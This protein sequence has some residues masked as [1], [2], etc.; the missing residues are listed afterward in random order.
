MVSVFFVI[1]GYALSLKPLKMMR[2]RD[3]DGFATTMTSFIFRRG[4]RLFIPTAVSTLMVVLLLRA[5]AYEWTRDFANDEHFLRN[6]RE[7]HPVRLGSTTEQMRDWSWNMFNFVHIWGWEKFGGST[8]Y[9]V[10]LWTI[11]VEFR[12]SMVLFLTLIGTARLRT[13]VRALA[14]MLFK[15][16]SYRNGRWEM[17]LFL[18]GMTIAEWDLIRG[19]HHQQRQ[20]AQMARDIVPVR[21]VVASSAEKRTNSKSQCSRLERIIPAPW[22]ALSFVSLY[23]MSQPDEGYATTPGWVTL[24]S[25][26]PGWFDDGFRFYQ[27]LGAMLF[28]LSVTHSPLWQRLFNTSAVQYLG[29]ISYA[30]YL[31]HGPVLHTIGYAIE[32]WAWG[33]TGTEG[34]GYIGGFALA[35]VLIVPIVVWA[36]DL[37]WRAVDAPVVRLAK[38]MESKC[39]VSPD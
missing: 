34:N 1:S 12:A 15:W 27:C 36:A 5:G 20:H 9:D 16:F 8:G 4:M 11:P 26:I 21:G 19:A 17:V 29:R 33:I 35:S 37:F 23:L 30:I 7:H 18:A 2:S 25:F 24:S 31:V 6:V 10:H 13:G 32:R 22:F 14:V 38:W 3:M 39:S 28:V